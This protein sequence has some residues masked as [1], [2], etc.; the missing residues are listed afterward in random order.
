MHLDLSCISFYS[1]MFSS[2][3]FDQIQELVWDEQTEFI[4]TVR[5]DIMSENHDLGPMDLIELGL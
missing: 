5:E 3:D 4:E 1:H 2:F